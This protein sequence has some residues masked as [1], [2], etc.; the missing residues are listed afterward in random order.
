MRLSPG[1]AKSRALWLHLRC[2]RH[3]HWQR[4]RQ[5]SLLQRL[6]AA[7][8]SC[9]LAAPA[10]A[11]CTR[12]F[13]AFIIAFNRL[14][15]Y[16][17]FHSVLCC[18]IRCARCL[19]SLR[20]LPNTPCAANPCPAVGSG[21]RSGQVMTRLA[22][23][24]SGLPGLDARLSS[25]D[26]PSFEPAMWAAVFGHASHIASLAAR[27]GARYAVACCVCAVRC[28]VLGLGATDAGC[29]GC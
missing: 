20:L 4:C 24:P 19:Y 12:F 7:G 8:Y 23:V 21:L 10:L 27:G 5:R 13:H 15:V 17:V 6:P 11:R 22:E 16:A 18:S 1:L 3:C 25:H 28:S 29:T 2:R 9:L 14:P 26:R